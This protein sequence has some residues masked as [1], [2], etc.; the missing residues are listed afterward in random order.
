[1]VVDGIGLILPWVLNVTFMIVIYGFVGLRKEDRY[2]VLTVFGLLRSS[3]SG[4]GTNM[5]YF[6]QAWSSLMRISDFIA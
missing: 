5:N 4:L 3:V 6:A 2:F 1:M